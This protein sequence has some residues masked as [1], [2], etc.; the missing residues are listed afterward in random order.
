MTE[1]Q[2]KAAALVAMLLVAI[3]ALLLVWMVLAT[4]GT[5]SLGDRFPGNFLLAVAAD[6]GLGITTLKLLPLIISTGLSFVVPKDKGDWRFLVT[7]GIV[8][9]GTL[10]SIYLY[11]ALQDAE[12]AH[13]FWSYSRVALLSSP[14]AINNDVRPT[15]LVLAGWFI[16]LLAVQLGIKLNG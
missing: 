9:L 8:L 7:I 3:P 4:M 13:R 14:D 6:S 12:L 11:F 2:R 1:Y 16:G 5:G 10:A 15:L